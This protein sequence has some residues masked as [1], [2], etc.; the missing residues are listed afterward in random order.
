VKKTIIGMAGLIVVAVGIVIFV[1]SNLDRM[2]KG[3]IQTYGSEATKTQVSVA[4]VNLRLE[5]GQAGISGLTVANPGGFTDPNIF[6]IG[7]ISVK[8]DAT[9]VSQNPLVIDE[10]SISSPVVIYE[11]NTSG[12]SNVDVLKKNLGSGVNSRASSGGGG[13]ALKMIIRKL[14][15]QG[16]SARIRIAALGNQQQSVAL[17][18]IVMRDVGKKSGG[19]TAAE[20]ARQL[21]SELL[22]N[23]KRSVAKFGVNKYLGTSAEAFKKN[24]QDRVKR[25][26]GGVAGSAGGAVGKAGDAIKGL[27]GK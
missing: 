15:V 2:V 9:T 7:N 6:E 1:W 14:A 4:R 16:S 25:I 24:A 5:S 22:G 27:F 8:I 12:I 19:A 26:G 17:P 3:A 21:S 20:V 10:I 18:G 11:I 13:E 23:V